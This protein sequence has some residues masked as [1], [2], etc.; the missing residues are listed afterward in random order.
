MLLRNSVTRSH[1]GVFSSVSEAVKSLRLSRSANSRRS[2]PTRLSPWD[3]GSSLTSSSFAPLSPAS[4]TSSTVLWMTV[5][6]ITSSKLLHASWPQLLS[7]LSCSSLE[8][9]LFRILWYYLWHSWRCNLS[10][11]TKWM[12]AVKRKWPL[13]GIIHQWCNRAKTKQR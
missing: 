7:V 13:S 9:L 5:S 1:T 12:L 4:L 8:S 6:S 11:T 2:S 10:K 3:C